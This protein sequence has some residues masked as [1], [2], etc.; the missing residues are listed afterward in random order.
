[1]N[2]M[3]SWQEQYL[4]R[5]LRSLVRCCCH[6]NI[7]FISSRHRVISSIYA[8]CS[9]QN[10]SAQPQAD[11][12]ER[13]RVFIK[14]LLLGPVIWGPM[15]WGNVGCLN[16]RAPIQRS[17]WLKNLR[18]ELKYSGRLKGRITSTQICMMDI[19]TWVP[20]FPVSCLLVLVH[21]TFRTM[22]LSQKQHSSLPSPI[23]QASFLSRLTFWYSYH[24]VSLLIKEQI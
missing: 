15:V 24:F 19:L 20:V 3:F 13:G 5:S 7:K 22:D 1:M 16:S 18:K 10:T 11:A 12:W 9:A 17:T 4:T 6:S 8:R 2:F 14:S 21:E 23:V